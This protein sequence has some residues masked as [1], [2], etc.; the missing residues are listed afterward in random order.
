M[1]QE[2]KVY[3]GVDVSKKTLDARIKGK[4]VGFPNTVKGVKSLMARAGDVHFIFESTG[5]YERMAAWMIMAKGKRAS[6]VNPARVRHFAL[7]MGQ[8]A[9]TDRIDARIITEFAEQAK[10]EP[11]KKPS[12]QQRTLT[13]R[14][15]R[16]QQLTGILTAETNRLDTLGD[17]ISRK[18]VNKHVKW[19][20]KQIRT[21]E[22]NIEQSIK[23]YPEMKTKAE[24]IQ[25][26]KGLGKVCSS[27]LLAH[28]P[29]IGSISRQEI[30]A[31]AGLAPYNKDSGTTCF[32]RHIHGGR[33][34]IR[35][36]LY[37]ASV[38][39]IRHN[40]LMKTYYT[41]LTEKNHRPHKVALVAVMR[42]LLIAANSSVKNPNFIVAV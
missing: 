23:E 36:C 18:L 12:K 30:T 21:L 29:E 38:C 41:H 3:C 22:A 8:F 27:T 9:K 39:A 34:R 1:N 25:K 26:I 4:T 42:K 35:Q 28:I 5:G 20:Q 16:R 17:P 33:K 7:S 2:E 31:L 19:I 32:K 40:P 11:A 10:P 6:I 15:D 24:A 13:A 37:M 14:V